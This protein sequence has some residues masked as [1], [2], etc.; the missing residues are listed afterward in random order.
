[1]LTVPFRDHQVR[2]YNYEFGLCFL[3]VILV[4][5]LQPK[6]VKDF[7]SGSPLPPDRM[8]FEFH[9]TCF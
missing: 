4:F 2:S 3:S 7:Y 5:Y 8:I 6:K 9:R 1:M